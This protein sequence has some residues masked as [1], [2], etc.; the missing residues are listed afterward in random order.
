[1]KKWSELMSAS[2]IF[3]KNSIFQIFTPN[4]YTEDNTSPYYKTN[5]CIQ[6]SKRLKTKTK[7]R[8]WNKMIKWSKMS[9]RN[10]KT[11]ALITRQIVLLLYFVFANYTSL[12][13]HYFYLRFP[14]WLNK[15]HKFILP[16]ILLYFTCF[17]NFKH[18]SIF[19]REK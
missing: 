10:S 12:L 2:S 16:V 9:K 1:M 7:I 18:F 11:Q 4:F 6:D 17:C 13:T 5:S 15:L 8:K 3:L 19:Y 14:S